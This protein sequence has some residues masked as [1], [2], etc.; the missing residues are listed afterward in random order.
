MILYIYM[1][2]S[3]ETTSIS[4]ACF[5]VSFQITFIFKFSYNNYNDSVYLKHITQMSYLPEG[6]VY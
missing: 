4:P 1:Y 2:K 3:K 5:A 6:R